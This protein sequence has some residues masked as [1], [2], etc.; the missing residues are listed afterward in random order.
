[1]TGGIVPGGT[2]ALN[3]GGLLG[4]AVDG[5]VPLDVSLPETPVGA[6]DL[7]GNS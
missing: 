2:D 4:G 7:G 5:P 6:F 1:M 3:D